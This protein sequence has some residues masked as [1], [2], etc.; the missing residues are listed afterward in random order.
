MTRGD[1]RI[2]HDRV[3]ICQR[4]SKTQ[5]KVTIG[6]WLPL[7]R[8]AKSLMCPHNAISHLLKASPTRTSRQPFSRFM[9]ETQCLWHISHASFA[10]HWAILAW[11]QQSLRFTPSVGAVPST[12]RKLVYSCL[13]SLPT[14]VGNPTYLQVRAPPPHQSSLLR[15]SGA[16]TNSPVGGLVVIG[17]RLHVDRTG[18][19]ITVITISDSA[20]FHFLL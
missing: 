7:P 15:P 19:L 13:S 20:I 5:Q 17:L 3:E 9:M 2:G 8:T 12:S 11:L 10:S 1:I 6:R 16:G 4:W 18:A 14:E